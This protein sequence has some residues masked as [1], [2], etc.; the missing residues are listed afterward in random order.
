MGEDAE[1]KMAMCCESRDARENVI[2]DA[3]VNRGRSS[4]L[5]EQLLDCGIGGYSG[6]QFGWLVNIPFT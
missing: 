6:V 4:T 3:A 2:R 1:G 5:S